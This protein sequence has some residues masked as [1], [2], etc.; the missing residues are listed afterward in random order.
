MAW[1]LI[2]NTKF[3]LLRFCSGKDLKKKTF[4]WGLRARVPP[5]VPIISIPQTGAV[6]NDVLDSF[7]AAGRKSKT[8][9]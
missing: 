7:N 4:V 6:T 1:H 2:F 5:P 8:S 3:I 9:R